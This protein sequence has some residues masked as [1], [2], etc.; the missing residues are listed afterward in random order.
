MALKIMPSIRLYFPF[1]L[2]EK[3]KDE[4][5]SHRSFQQKLN[6]FFHLYIFDCLR[7]FKL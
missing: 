1:L 4:N 5:I 6:F 7:F 2:F 3:G